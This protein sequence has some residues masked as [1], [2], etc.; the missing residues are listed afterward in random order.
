M[1][2]LAPFT[3]VLFLEANPKTETHLRINKEIREVKQALRGAKY[4]DR[5]EL[6]QLGAVRIEDFKA[7]LFD[8]KPRIVHFSGH[9]KETS[10]ESE[11]GLV[12]EDEVFNEDKKIYEIVHKI[13]PPEEIADFFEDREAPVECVVLN[14]CFTKDTAREVSRNVRFVIGMKQKILDEDAIRFSKYF[15]LALGAGKSIEAAFDEG[16]K[17]L[18]DPSLAILKENSKI[19]SPPHFEPR[20]IFLGS[21]AS[22]ALVILFRIY[23]GLQGLEIGFYDFLQLSWSRGRDDRILII[24]ATQEDVLI[25]QQ[26]GEDVVGSF[27]NQTLGNLLEEINSLNPAVIGLDIYRENFLDDAMEEE[28]NLKNILAEDDVF[29]ICKRPQVE[30]GGT[31]R[32]DQTVS[33]AVAPS[34]HIA[35]NRIGFSDFLLDRDTIVRRHV[36]GGF[37]D[38][39]GSEQDCL[40]SESFNLIVANH[41]LKTQNFDDIEADMAAGIRLDNPPGQHC[42]VVLP[43]GKVSQSLQPFTGGYQGELRI[44]A[45]CQVLLKYRVDEDTYQSAEMFTVQQV[46]QGALAGRDLTETIVLVGV[47]RTDGYRDYWNTPYNVAMGN[48]MPGV[49]LHAQMISQLLDASLGKSPLIW[50]MPFWGEWLWILLWSSVGGM[51][52]WKI[53]L[54][55]LRLGTLVMAG[56]VGFVIC[57]VGFQAFYGWL[58]FVPIVLVL[59][60]APL[61]SWGVDHGRLWLYKLRKY[62]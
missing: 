43:N 54:L 58:P 4:R 44:E 26:N 61:S 57:Y 16:K 52:V 7:E 21:L 56:G 53:Q 9:G 30:E 41:Y 25:Q 11:G 2:D 28:R 38:R 37:G 3:K 15:Y 62:G 33:L 60:A 24:Q 34:P 27:S 29:G 45:A 32:S 51:I 55:P 18:S 50:V 48:Q 13:V 39:F 47:T 14:G 17:Q 6:N 10:A 20:W 40:A 8:Y 31:D 36:L 35:E 5:I 42:R 22:A 49:M 23:G 59:A 1:S 46:L 12:F 19:K